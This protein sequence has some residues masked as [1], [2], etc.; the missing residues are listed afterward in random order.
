M[1]YSYKLND[2]ELGFSLILVENSSNNKTLKVNLYNETFGMN[3]ISHL[4]NNSHLPQSN[5][6]YYSSTNFHN[7]TL[8]VYPLS[9]QIIIFEWIKNLN[10]KREN[11]IN[12][13]IAFLYLE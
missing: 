10:A 7:I 9:Y 3:I 2:A 12:C 13:L 5:R 8:T 1:L 4:N 11:N 6:S